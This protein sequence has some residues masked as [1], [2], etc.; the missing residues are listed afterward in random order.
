M[1]DHNKKE[2]PFFK[3]DCRYDTAAICKSLEENPDIFDL[4]T[5]RTESYASAHKSVSDVWVRYN[6]PENIG[7]NFNDC[8][9]PVWYPAAAIVPE[10]VA[11]AFDL[12]TRVMGEHL[13]GIL[14]TKIKSGEGVLPHIDKGWHAAFYEKFYV[15]LKN[16]TGARLCFDD[17]FIEPEDGEVYCFDN[18]VT[19]WVENNSD[20]DRLAMIVCIRTANRGLMNVAA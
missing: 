14:I 5:S 17:G 15:A 16:N 13:G 4:F 3:L 1:L 20:S 18:S 11:I 6:A 8:H 19:H 7:D 10:A 9:F 2:P 12:M